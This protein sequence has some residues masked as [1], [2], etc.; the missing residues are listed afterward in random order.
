MRG[1]KES[2]QINNIKKEKKETVTKTL[3]ILMILID[4]YGQLY[5]NNFEN[6]E[7]MKNLLKTFNLLKL[8]PEKRENLSSIIIIKEIE[9]MI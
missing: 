4:Y 2:R 5:A 3:K 1:K 8:T 9:S 6:L 7:I